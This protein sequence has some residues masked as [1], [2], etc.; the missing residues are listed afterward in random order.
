MYGLCELSGYAR[1][2]Q[3]EAW[4]NGAWQNGVWQNAASKIPLDIT[5]LG[6][7]QPVGKIKLGVMR[8]RE[9][10]I[11]GSSQ[12]MSKCDI[13]LQCRGRH[14]KI[15]PARRHGK[16]SILPKGRSGAQRSVGPRAELI[17]WN[18]WGRAWFLWRPRLCKWVTILQGCK[19]LEN[20]GKNPNIEKK[21]K[22]ILFGS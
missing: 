19:L 17:F 13:H 4:Q 14:R 10:L 3:N 15:M 5:T 9:S 22:K 2:V 18:A 12:S 1:M 7:T 20:R 16:K 21:V 6:T 8:P 11:L